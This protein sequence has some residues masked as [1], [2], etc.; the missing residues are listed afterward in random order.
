VLRGKFKYVFTLAMLRFFC[1]VKSTSVNKKRNVRV[2][3]PQGAFTT[4]GPFLTDHIS[5]ASDT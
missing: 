2:R 5:G 1:L 4:S 3:H